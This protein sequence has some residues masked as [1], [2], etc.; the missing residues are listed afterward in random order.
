MAD[1]VT[2][3]PCLDNLRLG[4]LSELMEEEMRSAVHR[5]I[6]VRAACALLRER[7]PA[8]APVILA[9]LAASD[10]DLSERELD[11]LGDAASQLGLA[12][13]E[14]QH[15]LASVFGPLQG[16]VGREAAPLPQPPRQPTQ[17]EPVP[18]PV[19]EPGLARALHVLGV[20]A[21]ADRA[22]LDASY[23]RLIERYDPARVIDLGPDFATLAVRKLIEVTD[24]YEL[25]THALEL[26]N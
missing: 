24:A 1:E 9:A 20:A 14:A 23:R 6:D 4:R 13:A 12:P 21:S 7:L 8:A 22:D 17:P 3:L 10:R 2:A 18:P 19:L 16:A 26:Q 5:P 15:I 11:I 25:A